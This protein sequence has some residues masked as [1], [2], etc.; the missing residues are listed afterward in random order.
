MQTPTRLR[1]AKGLR[2]YLS[3]AKDLELKESLE[4]QIFGT[5]NLADINSQPLQSWGPSLQ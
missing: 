3:C 1:G 4:L 5:P 2:D